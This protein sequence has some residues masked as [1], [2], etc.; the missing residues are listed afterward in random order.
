MQKNE[1]VAIMEETPTY[2]CMHT[3]T[4]VYHAMMSAA[5]GLIFILNCHC[6][7]YPFNLWSAIEVAICPKCRPLVSYKPTYEHM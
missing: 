5:K 1:H 4:H 7:A 3:G 2:V 6:R